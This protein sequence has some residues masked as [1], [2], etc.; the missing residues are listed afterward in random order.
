MSDGLQKITGTAMR[1]VLANMTSNPF[2][3]IM[4]GFLVTALV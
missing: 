4:T 1:N 2:I 3:G